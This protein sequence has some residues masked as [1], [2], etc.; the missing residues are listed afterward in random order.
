MN[1]VSLLVYLADVLQTLDWVAFCGVV[2]CIFAVIFLTVRQAKDPNRFSLAE[3]AEKI[4]DHKRRPNLYPDPGPA[5]DGKPWVRPSLWKAI[6]AP[7]FTAI[8]CALVMVFT[9]SANTVYAIAASQAAERV[10]KSPTVTK[11]VNALNRWLDRQA[12]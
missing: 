7:T 9:P 8:G 12:K 5:P 2:A 11:A 3:W 6:K 1:F 10:I 4:A